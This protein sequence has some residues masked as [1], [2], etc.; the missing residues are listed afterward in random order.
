MDNVEIAINVFQLF[1]FPLD[2]ECK[3]ELKCLCRCINFEIFLSFSIVAFNNKYNS[4]N[5][6]LLFSSWLSGISPSLCLL[7]DNDKVKSSIFG[8]SAW[9]WLR[10]KGTSDRCGNSDLMT[11]FIQVFPTVDNYSTRV[12][13]LN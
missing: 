6:F 11:P 5:I 12:D 1:F 2:F 4:R 10:S 8:L 7:K 13:L 3:V 9:Q